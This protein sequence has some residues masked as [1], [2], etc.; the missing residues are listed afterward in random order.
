VN[1]AHLPAGITFLICAAIV[2]VCI[3]RLDK[4]DRQVRL[5][6]G[7]QYVVLLMAAGGLALAPL[8]G[9]FPDWAVTAFAAAVL[10]MLC[11]DSFQ[12]HHGPPESASAPTPL[13]EF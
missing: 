2:S 11:A 6:V 1:A 7:I 10:F 5:R 4:I 9:Q 3:C 12:W 13:S 8:L